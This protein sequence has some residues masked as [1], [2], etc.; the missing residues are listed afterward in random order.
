M[1]FVAEFSWQAN[2]VNDMKQQ[3]VNQMS[4]KSFN[5]NFEWD[6]LKIHG[7]KHHSSILTMV[8]GKH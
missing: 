2:N 1:I 8:E 3:A 5:P 4:S 6:L 7:K